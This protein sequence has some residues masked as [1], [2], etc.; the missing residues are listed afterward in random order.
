MNLA[1]N[2]ELTSESPV[3]LSVIEEEERRR[4]FWS[5]FVLKRL[6]G[7]DFNILDFTGDENFPNYPST[8]DR[9]IDMEDQVSPIEPSSVEKGIVAY[10]IQL[11]EVW[12]KIAKYARGR[13]KPSAVLPWSPQSE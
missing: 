13:G 1:H 10:A 8:P 11:S 2:A 7:T 3:K 5:L 12:F 6:H 9:P 4:C